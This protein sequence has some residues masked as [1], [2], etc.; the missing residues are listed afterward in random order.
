MKMKSYKHQF[1]DCTLKGYTNETQF[2]SFKEHPEMI[3]TFP[4]RQVLED[5]K[6]SKIAG[7]TIIKCGRFGGNCDSFN[8]KCIELRKNELTVQKL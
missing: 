2:Y 5:I 7:V 4:S 6:S 3:P 8:E 1:T